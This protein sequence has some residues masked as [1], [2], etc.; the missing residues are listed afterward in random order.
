LRKAAK[1][2][3]IR[4]VLPETHDIYFDTLAGIGKVAKNSTEYLIYKEREIIF[5][6]KYVTYFDSTGNLPLIAISNPLEIR[7]DSA[8]NIILTCKT[9]IENEQI[10]PY[11]F[12][13]KP[14]DRYLHFSV[15]TTTHEAEWQIGVYTLN[16]DL[17][18]NLHDLDL[19]KDY[20][21]FPENLNYIANQATTLK[22]IFSMLSDYTKH[23]DKLFKFHQL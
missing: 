1:D 17:I 13:Y 10:Y 7:R 22:S 5:I 3:V 12:N 11:I 21:G 16:N 4:F 2:N 14:D 6:R 19:K 18:K 9:R 8:V 15:L 23:V 20:H